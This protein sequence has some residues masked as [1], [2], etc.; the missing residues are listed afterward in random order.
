MLV[1]RLQ[2]RG[3]N[4]R[5]VNQ[6]HS[7]VPTM[8]QRRTDPDLLIYL[9]VSQETASKR[10]RSEAGATWWKALNQRLQHAYRHADLLVET[11]DLTPGE[12]LNRVLSF[13]DRRE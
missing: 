1:E 3:Y 11:D 2:Q 6:E 8:W 12:V 5:E 13:L 9:D 7:Y 10:R 4:A